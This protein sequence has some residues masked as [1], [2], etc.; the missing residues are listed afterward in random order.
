MR[1]QVNATRMEL[2]RLQRRL[3]L[4][5]RGHKLL[6]DKLDEL[7]R[8]F[9][10]MSR[11]VDELRE[12][13]EKEW[14][15]LLEHYLMARSQVA[16]RDMEEVLLSP[17]EIAEIEE[18]T[19]PVLN[20][21]VP[22]FQLKEKKKLINYGFVNTTG[23]LDIALVSLGELFPKILELASLEKGVILLG[24]EIKKTRRKV[25]ALEYKMIPDLEETLDYIYFRLSEL[26]RESII[27]IMKVSEK[28]RG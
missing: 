12:E 18:D 14:L 19:R 23:D 17:P 5:R 28:I 27:R 20:L 25:N 11:R 3:D 16:Y 26:E 6:R 1:L 24:E 8:E 9:L 21:K 13:V 7:V 4:A 10:K 22:Q 2:L 15:Q